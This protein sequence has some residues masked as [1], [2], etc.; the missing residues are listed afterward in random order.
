MLPYTFEEF[1]DLIEHK[2]GVK[3]CEY[4]KILLRAYYEDRPIYYMPGRHHGLKMVT[5]AMQEYD[6]LLEQE[7]PQC[8]IT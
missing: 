2:F 7:E 5:T 4:Q 8:P 1:I 6:E 3:L